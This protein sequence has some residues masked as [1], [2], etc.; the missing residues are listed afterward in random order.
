MKKQHTINPML[1]LSGV[2]HDAVQAMQDGTPFVAMRRIKRSGVVYK[3]GDE[4]VLGDGPGDA[5]LARE[6]H[7]LPKERYEA[8]AAAHLAEEYERDVIA[9]ARTRLQQQQRTASAAA[10]HAASLESQLHAA[11]TQAATATANADKAYAEL[12][13][14]EKAIPTV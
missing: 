12:A 11:R 1:D 10:A 9:P 2:A 4:L 13:V 3:L 5:V 14:L 6:G 7:A 8:Q